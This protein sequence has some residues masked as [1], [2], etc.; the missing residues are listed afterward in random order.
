[1]YDFLWRRPGAARDRWA[2]IVSWILFAGM[3][4][5]FCRILSGRAAFV[6]VGA[7]MGTIMVANVWLRILPAQQR[8][9]DATRAGRTPDFTEGEAAKRRS[10][11]NSYLTF[12]VLFLMLSTHFP[13]LHGGTN[14]VFALGLI[15]GIGVAARHL[16]IGGKGRAWAAVPLAAALAAAIVGFPPGRMAGAVQDGAVSDSTNPRPATFTHVQAIVLSRCVACH[17]A[18]PRID[19]F[20]A[21]PGG[22]SFDDPREIRR[23]ARRLGVRVVHTRTMP[24]G[25]MTEMTTEERDVVARWLARGAPAD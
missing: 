5:A 2:A 11:H 7:L 10:V 24:L 4:W 8:M 17:S 18:T 12:P 21:A 9:I 3:A 15:T 19:A 14:N 13:G 1:V 25:N 23:W 16:M 22:V 20:G 6:H